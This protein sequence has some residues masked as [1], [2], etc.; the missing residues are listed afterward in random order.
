MLAKSESSMKGSNPSNYVP[1]EQLSLLCTL[2][3][4]LRHQA[5]YS[6]HNDR[7]M[8]SAR[9]IEKQRPPP[10]SQSLV[11]LCPSS[12]LSLGRL[13]HKR[14]TFIQTAG[15]IETSGIGLPSSY[16][17]PGYVVAEGFAFELSNEL[18]VLRRRRLVIPSVANGLCGG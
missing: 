4:L 2:G 6:A 13:A 12:S 9:I 16:Q 18:R 15:H 1:A 17:S 5:E 8:P 10:R 11:S 3:G 7:P 14:P